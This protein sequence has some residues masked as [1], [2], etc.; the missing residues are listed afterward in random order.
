M[1]DKQYTVKETAEILRIS[2]VT[3]L[4]YINDGKIKNT[5]YSGNKHII[6]ESSIKEFLSNG[7]SY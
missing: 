2:V 1:I 6:P 5:S 4:R 3:V 7:G